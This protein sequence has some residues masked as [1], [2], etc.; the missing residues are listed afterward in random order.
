MLLNKKMTLLEEK[1]NTNAVMLGEA[2]SA[3]GIAPDKVGG[4][5]R[6]MREVVEE[7]GQAAAM[8]AAAESDE[9]LVADAVVRA[10]QRSSLRRADGG[11]GDPADVERQVVEHVLR[12]EMG[13]SYSQNQFGGGPAVQEASEWQLV[14]WNGLCLGNHPA[15]PDGEKAPF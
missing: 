11:S 1:I 10:T 5:A 12:L 4:V 15:L 14:D 13:L 3:A 9:I 8:F 7:N 6:R 2:I